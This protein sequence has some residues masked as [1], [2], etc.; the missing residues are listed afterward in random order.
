MM[1]RREYFSRRH[2]RALVS[3]AASGEKRQRGDDSL[4]TADIPLKET[5]HRR[6]SSHIAQNLFERGLLGSREGERK[7]AAK[8][9]N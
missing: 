4:T 2:E 1:L 6:W 5:Q 8:F 3:R 9:I 7:L